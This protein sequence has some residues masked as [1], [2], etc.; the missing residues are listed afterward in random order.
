MQS[1]SQPISSRLTATP[2][3]DFGELQAR[4]QAMG[5]ANRALAV[6]EDAKPALSVAEEVLQLLLGTPQSKEIFATLRK[7][8]VLLDRM[9][10]SEAR[11][12]LMDSSSDFVETT[13]HKLAAWHRTM[14]R[15]S[16]GEG[17][18]SDKNREYIPG[19]EPLALAIAG[20]SC[21]SSYLS[22]I[23]LA[24]NELGKKGGDNA[25][26]FASAMVEIRR[27]ATLLS[28]CEIASGI[29]RVVN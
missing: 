28:D 24:L 25:A 11:T 12:H 7:N 19:S 20:N 14:E 18:V 22:I 13:R 3:V 29:D 2:L 10:P 26:R 5:L 4:Y 27:C 21:V 8:S 16:K 9:R 15:I 23:Q 6:L 1:P 17:I